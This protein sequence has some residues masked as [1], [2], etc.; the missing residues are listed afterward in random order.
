MTFVLNGY[1]SNLLKF[2]VAWN[3]T[4][5]SLLIETGSLGFHDA[6]LFWVL[7]CHWLPSYSLFCCVF[8]LFQSSQSWTASRRGPITSSL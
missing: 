8:H 4:D 2:K 5:F 7:L 1:F 6:L 3:I